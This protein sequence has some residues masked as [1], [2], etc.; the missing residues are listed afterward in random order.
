VS[1]GEAC[2]VPHRP[3]LVPHARAALLGW[4]AYAAL[5]VALEVS[6]IGN[7]LAVTGPLMLALVVARRVDVDGASIVPV[8]RGVA[9]A[10]ATACAILAVAVAVWR[11]AVFGIS[12]IVLASLLGVGAVATAVMLIDRARA[13]L[14]R[15]LGLDPHSAVHVVTALAFVVALVFALT[16]FVE[17]EDVSA[18]PVPVDYSDALVAIAGDGALALAGVGFLQTRGLRATVER[19]GLRPIGVRGVLTA[20]VL[21][22]ALHALVGS[23][24]H[25]ESWLLPRIAALEE[26][27]DYE[28]VGI[29][30]VL[31]GIVLSI[32]V[33]IGE[34]LLFRGALQPRVGIVAT[35]ALFAAFHVQYQVPG[36]LMIFFVGLALGVARRRMS[37]TFTIVVHAL[38]DIAAFF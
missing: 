33:G 4:L 14:L 31:G 38:Y 11:M 22:A 6:G 18:E 28:F 8:L 17:S 23:L 37:T 2:L 10:L 30:P 24:E 16:T 32:A 12:A 19:L 5:C 26:R 13:C 1:D 3:A 25:V 29:S 7:G 21:A 20:V 36:I 27:F 34:E 35:A 15:P 9:A